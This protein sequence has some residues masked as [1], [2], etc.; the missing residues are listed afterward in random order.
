MEKI[1][2]LE[3]VLPQNDKDKVKDAGK[4]ASTIGLKKVKSGADDA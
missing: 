2:L 3:D 4:L 1:D